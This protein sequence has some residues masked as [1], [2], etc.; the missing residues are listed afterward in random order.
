M[1]LFM[2]YIIN[3]TEKT[4]TFPNLTHVEVRQKFCFFLLN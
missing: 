1:T 3:N 2:N 4:Q